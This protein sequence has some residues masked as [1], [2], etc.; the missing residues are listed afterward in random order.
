MLA[1]GPAA[2]PTLAI[3][4]FLLG[5]ANAAFSC[6]LLLGSLDPAD[7]LVAGQGRDVIP[8][9]ES[10]GI[11]DQ[12]LAQ[13]RGQFV[14]HATVD[15]LSAHDAKVAARR[16]QPHVWSTSKPAWSLRPRSLS[17]MLTVNW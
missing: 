14:H 6:Y 17:Q 10:R 7:E 8:R 4:E 13:V 3:L 5:P 15:S 1:P 16:A 9:F 11:R 12:R 2:G